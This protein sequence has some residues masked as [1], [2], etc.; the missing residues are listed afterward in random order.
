VLSP[1]HRA[2]TDV[3]TMRD[4]ARQAGVSVKTVSRVF[5]RDPHVTPETRDRVER[6]LRALD[7]SPNELARTFRAGRD[8]AL[9]VVVPDI[10]DPFF[11]PL[12]RSVEDV[13]ASRGIAVVVASSRSD[14]D[15]ERATVESL[16]NRQ[17]IGLISTPISLD[18]SYL[19]P[20]Q[21]RT[22]IVCVDRVPQGLMADSF[23]EDDH[24]A[25]VTATRHLLCYGHR[26]VAFAG[27]DPAVPTTR[28][29][30]DGYRS[31]LQ[32]V[33]IVP[34]PELVLL[35][36]WSDVEGRTQLTRLLSSSDPPTALFSSNA[37]CSAA[38]IQA[39]QYL[40]RTDI[41]L[42]SFGD[43][44]L[45]GSVNPPLTVIDQEPGA[46]GRLAAERIFARLDNAGR[47]MKRKTVIQLRLIPRGSGEQRPP[48]NHPLAM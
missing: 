22:P 36:Q 47:R 27:D 26:R 16:L 25:A 31:A 24:G 7:Y 4:V 14:P 1:A 34:D 46:L 28:L 13:A 15:R 18:Q 10:G 42:V 39:L 6:S 8:A 9:G 3:A 40:H 19:A 20:W 38:A 41:A 45:A 2:T 35:G 17:I 23:V 29:R 43:L 48:D 30:M 32:E 5:N 11:A 21:P 12:V 33:G 44:P 37:R